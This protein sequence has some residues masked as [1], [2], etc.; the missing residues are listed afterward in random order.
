MVLQGDPTDPQVSNIL[1]ETRVFNRGKSLAA[2]PHLGQ[3][4]LGRDLQKPLNDVGTACADCKC[5][6]ILPPA[7]SSTCCRE[8]CRSPLF[9]SHLRSP[10]LVGISD[11]HEVPATNAPSTHTSNTARAKVHLCLSVLHHLHSQHQAPAP[12]VADDIMLL[13]QGL[14]ALLNL[15][16]NLHNP[17]FLDTAGKA[18]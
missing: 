10:L 6:G 16:S 15:P 18:I 3:L 13:H 17:Q 9:F 2:L 4:P 1:Q 11:R 8:S 7:S 12:D 5:L 14:K